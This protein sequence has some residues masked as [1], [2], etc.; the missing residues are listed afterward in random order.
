MAGFKYAVAI[1]A[2]PLPKTAPVIFRGDL[3]A[4]IEKAKKIGYDAV[5]IHLRNPQDIDKAA[6]LD[7][8]ARNEISVSAL[9]TGAEA[10]LNGFSMLSPSID[11]RE[12]LARNLRAHVDLAGELDAL[13]IIGM[14]RGNLTENPD[15]ERELFAKQLA[16][17]ADYARERNVTLVLEAINSYVNNYLC[18]TI[19]C[20]DFVRSLSK[21]NV[22]LHIDTHHMNIEDYNPVESIH[23]AGKTI[24]YVHFC[25]INRMYP[26]A[27]CFDFPG[28]MRGLSEIGYDGYISLEC[29]PLPSPDEAATLGLSYLKELFT[30]IDR[31]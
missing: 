25:E 16:D 7:V 23:Y 17:L 19:D 4:S 22:L 31:R 6:L 20:C 5:E 10:T 28:I 27:G 15:E 29:L 3:C 14:L 1:T 9:A 30:N 2:E 26:G 24:G 8:C 18:S 21:E 11:L 13:V 12:Q